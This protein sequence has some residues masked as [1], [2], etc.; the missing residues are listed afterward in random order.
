M[1][2]TD[3]AARVHVT[4]SA[5]TQ[6]ER[7][8]F[9]PTTVVAARLSL[10]LGV[11]LE[12][13]S[14]SAA[15]PIPASAAHFRSLRSTPANRREQALAFAE[16]ALE[17]CIAI[18]DWVDLPPVS[19]PE[20]GGHNLAT[21]AGAASAAAAARSALGVVP[22]PVPHA[23]RLLESCGV[24]VLTL[25]DHLLDRRVDAFSTGVARRP[26]VLLSPMKDDKAR[27]R[28]DAAHE[29]GHLL[30]HHDVE[31][32]SRIAESQAQNFAAGFLA[33]ADEIV[34]D[35]P[36]RVDW[37][38]LLRAKRK[39]GISL[40]ALVYRA[41]TLELITDSAFRRANIQL[42]KWGHPERGPLGPPESPSILGRATRLLGEAGTSIEMIAHHASLPLEQAQQLV[43]AATN[44]RP[45]LT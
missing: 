32:G 14:S 5:I 26:L 45:A 29:L 37:E 9:R 8:D 23:V 28:F 27:S 10:A 40:R 4:P 11:P 19:L 1:P 17:L 39:W 35:L 16:L 36:R 44:D 15:E 34:D 18:E 24:L 3:L 22:G 6:L 30:L 21:A 12:F 31:P 13:F 7:G 41:H 43:A 20:L 42:S 2:K 38:A 33:P 25:P